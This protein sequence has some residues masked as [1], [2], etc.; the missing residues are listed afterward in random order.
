MSSGIALMNREGAAL[1]ADTAVTTGANRV[2]ASAQ[3]VHPLFE[4]GRV[5]LMVFGG[6]SVLHTPWSGIAVDFARHLG[7]KRYASLE[8]YAAELVSFL[9]EQKRYFDAESQAAFVAD[10]AGRTF[11]DACELLEGMP[12]EFLTSPLEDLKAAV[13]EVRRRILES[14]YC[15]ALPRNYARELLALYGKVIDA[16]LIDRLQEGRAPTALR[17]SFRSTVVERVRRRHPDD[18]ESGVVLVGFGEKDRFPVLVELGI[19]GVAADLALISVEEPRRIGPKRPAVVQGFAQHPAL[20]RLQFGIDEDLR[21]ALVGSGKSLAAA[22]AVG[23]FEATTALKPGSDASKSLG[24]SAAETF[25]SAFEVILNHVAHKRNRDLHGVIEGMPVPRLAHVAKG[26]IDAQIL[27]SDLASQPPT[28]GGGVDFATITRRDGFV[29]AGRGSE[30]L[31][32]R[33]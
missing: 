11:D 6:A 14:Q 3:K 31:S 17:D 15:D 20:Q 2:H 23:T 21:D 18:S 16:V 13:I 1:A 10:C 33:A 30:A 28:V 5:A 26:L 29:W 12:E 19:R 9:G 24:D 22:L 25:A 8:E 27:T 4:N 7:R 32:L